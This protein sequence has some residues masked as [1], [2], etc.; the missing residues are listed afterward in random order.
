M[1][2]EPR[3]PTLYFDPDAHPDNTLKIFNEFCDA[4]VLRYNALYPDPPKVS[5]DAALSR[6]KLTTRTTENP[7]PT[8]TVQQYDQVRDNWRSK[9]C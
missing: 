6:W 7:D 5:M 8:P 9:D 4:F 1:E 3:S 2:H